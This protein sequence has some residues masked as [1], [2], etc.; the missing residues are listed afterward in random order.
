M[1]V[2]YHFERHKINYTAGEFEAK[3]YYALSEMKDELDNSF[4][5]LARRHREGMFTKM[6][7]KSK[8]EEQCNPQTPLE[9]IIT[10]EDIEAIEIKSPARKTGK[11]LPMTPANKKPM[12]SQALPRYSKRAESPHKINTPLTSF[13][14]IIDRSEKVTRVNQE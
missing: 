4:I 8:E 10:Q 9:S 13:T 7:I 3:S 11:S 14:K 5:N 6:Y 2:L 12:V 1:A